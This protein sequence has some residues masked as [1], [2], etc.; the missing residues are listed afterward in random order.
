MTYATHCS[1]GQGDKAVRG[2]IN[3]LKSGVWG[4]KEPIRGQGTLYTFLD[5]IVA[6]HHWRWGRCQQ[7]SVKEKIKELVM[8]ES[9]EQVNGLSGLK[10]HP[11][12][13]KQQ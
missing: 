11:Q 12:K 3:L 7:S 4:A 9:R 13:Q 10:T 8:T 1:T 6:E 2:L 5:I